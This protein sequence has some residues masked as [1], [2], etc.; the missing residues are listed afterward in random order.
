MYLAVASCGVIALVISRVDQTSAYLL[1]G[2][3]AVL[4][5]IAGLALGRVPVYD[6]VPRSN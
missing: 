2:L 6:P 1:G 5:L 3:V 4:A